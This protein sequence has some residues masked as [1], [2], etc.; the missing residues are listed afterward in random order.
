[1]KTM[2]IYEPAMCCETGICGVGVDPELLRISTVINNLKKNGVEIKRYNLNNF[3]QEFINNTEINK[4][5]MGDGVE[6]LPATV[7]D[8]KIVMTKKYPTN[9]EIANL[10]EVPKSYLEAMK[11]L[12][13][14]G[15][16]CCGANGG[17][18]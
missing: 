1:M 16:C 12:D 10:L 4:L 11:D 8:G 3:P 5:I 15:G 2:S 13:S 7:V 9:D 14:N 18:C 6:S 17:C